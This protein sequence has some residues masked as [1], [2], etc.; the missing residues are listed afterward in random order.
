MKVS[1]RRFETYV[2]A[3]GSAGKPLKFIS[4]NVVAIELGRHY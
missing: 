4:F 1:G 3:I 2:K